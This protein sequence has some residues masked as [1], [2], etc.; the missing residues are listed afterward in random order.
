VDDLFAG[1]GI[2]ARHTA[3]N[4]EGIAAI[5]SWINGR[6]NGLL[7]A[8]LV[9]F[10]QLWGHRNDVVGFHDG[11]RAFDRVLPELERHLL[12]NDVLFLTADH[13]NDPTT[14]STDHTRERVPLLAIGAHVRPGSL[15]ER[16]SFSDLGATVAELLGLSYRG[17]G[18][19]FAPELWRA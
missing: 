18:T 4:A 13:G 19:S 15:G 6:S 1:R 2:A 17:R 8:N 5:Q 10:D 14:P 16:A 9:D 7:F 12:E 3:S 11:L